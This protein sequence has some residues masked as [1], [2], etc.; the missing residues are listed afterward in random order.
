MALTKHSVE[1]IKN[2]TGKKTVK[3]L[4]Y[5]INTIQHQ[6]DTLLAQKAELQHELLNEMVYMKMIPFLQVNLK[7]LTKTILQDRL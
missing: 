6:I 5:S 3:E 4:A 7:K 1:P 2:D